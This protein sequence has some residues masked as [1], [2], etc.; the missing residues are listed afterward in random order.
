MTDDTIRSLRCA[1][2]WEASGQFPELVIAAQEHGRRVHNMAPT[3]EEVEAMLLP[4]GPAA[5]HRAQPDDA[6]SSSR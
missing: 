1:C 5:D 2:G 6:R 4:I 3:E